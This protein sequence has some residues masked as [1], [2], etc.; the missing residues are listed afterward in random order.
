MKH[1]SV[2]EMGVARCLITIFL[3]TGWC[4]AQLVFEQLSELF[5]LCRVTFCKH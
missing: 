2:S 5:T 3:C 1:V 4:V